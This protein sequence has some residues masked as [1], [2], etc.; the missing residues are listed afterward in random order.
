V[1]ARRRAWIVALALLA[2]P[3]G[4]SASPPTELPSAGGAVVAEVVDGDTVILDAAVEGSREVRLVGIQAPKL[5]LGRPDFPEWPLAPEAK[6]AL[7]GLLLGKRVA[8]RFGGQR[9]DR[10]G[11]LLAHLTG[12]GGL[13]AQGEMLRLGLARVYS[14]P[15]N[16]ALAAEMHALEREARAA[17]RGIWS[18]PYYAIVAPE[19][20]HRHLGTFQLV[21]GRVVDAAAAKGTVFLNFGPDWRTDFTVSISREAMKLFREAG[22]DPLALKGQRVRVRGWIERRNGPLIPASHP[23]QIEVLGS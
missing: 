18:H 16:R 21:E 5:A 23:E 14:F 3:V 8:L 7:E 11:R 2:A 19:R 13:W 4:G 20:T 10:H 22:I 12:E 15:D 1:S 6:R 17:R 9:R